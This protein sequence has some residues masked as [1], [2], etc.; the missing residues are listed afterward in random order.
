MLMWGDRLF[1][2][3]K[4]NWGE[5]EAAKNGTAGTVDLIPRDVIICP[6]HYELKKP[7]PSVPKILAKGFRVLQASWRKLDASRALI[8]YRRKQQVPKML[9]HLFTT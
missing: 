6:W 5:W 4:D 8:E 1:D 9:G 2:A 3:Q 7:Y